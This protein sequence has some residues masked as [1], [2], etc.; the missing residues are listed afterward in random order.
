M[1]RVTLR[2]FK[3]FLKIQKFKDKESRNNS[4]M[5]FE[6]IGNI[7]N[8]N[9]VSKSCISKDKNNSKGKVK[10]FECGGYG[11]ISSECAN[12]FK[13]QKDKNDEKAIALI[14]TVSLDE[15]LE[16]DDDCVDMNFECIMNK[17]DDF[18]VAS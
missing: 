10:C 4:S 2:Q 7:Y 6:K 14:A 16:K 11:H 1:D 5:D 3:S 18:L 12:T 8:T 15:P 13:K 9:V 17:Y